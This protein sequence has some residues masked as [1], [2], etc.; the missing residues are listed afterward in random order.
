[1][2]T[3]TTLFSF[4][5]SL[6]RYKHC[7]NKKVRWNELFYEIIYY[8]HKICSIDFSLCHKICSIDFSLCLKPRRAIPLRVHMPPLRG[9]EIEQI[10]YFLQILHPYGVNFIFLSLIVL[11]F[12]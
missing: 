11:D 4:A 1:M 3:E 5:K 10:H 9:L 2:P 8:N 12:I 7:E 6:Q